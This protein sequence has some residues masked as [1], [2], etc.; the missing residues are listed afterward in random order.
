MPH[1]QH[2]KHSQQK[3]K[4]HL[5]LVLVVGTPGLEHG[6]VGTA[7]AGNDTNGGA[8]SRQQGLLGAG[9]QTHAGLADLGHVSHNGDVVAGGAAEFATVSGALLA[10]AHDGTF[11]HGAEGQGVANLE[12]G[13]LAA[14]EEL[15]GVHA[16]SG[17]EVSLHG[18][19]PEQGCGVV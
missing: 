14:V 2:K 9:R 12:L 8:A 10:V 1:E 6:L 19:E 5:Y 11:G 3:Y 16:L 13:L 17:D 4:Q 15:A 18:L 7:T